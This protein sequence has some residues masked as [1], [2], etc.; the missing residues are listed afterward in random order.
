MA[1]TLRQRRY[2]MI[3][4]AMFVLAMGCVAAGTWQ[5][6]R[7]EQSVHDN[8]ALTGNA[9]AATVALSPS[10]VP[11][12][13]PAPGRDAIRFRTVTV[14]GSYLADVTVASGKIVNGDGGSYIVSPLRT[15]DG[16]IAVERG[17][18][19]A[20]RS[21]HLPPVPAAPAGTVT[22]TGR[23]DTF[24][25][26]DAA[27]ASAQARQSGVPLYPAVLKLAASQPGGDGLVTLPKPDL[28]NPAG[29]AYS[30]QHFAYVVQWYVFALI[31]L[32]A[33]FVLAR[34]EVAEAQ[35]R[36]LGVDAGELELG[37]QLESASRAK[38]D[39]S[40]A[41]VVV[42]RGAEV[43]TANGVD[44]P[45]L[46][47]AKRLADRYGRALSIG[48]DIPSPAAAPAARRDPL[49]VGGLTERVPESAEVPHRSHDSYHGSYNDY[50]WQLGLADG[51]A[52]APDLEGQRPELDGHSESP[53]AIT[54]RVIEVDDD[55]RR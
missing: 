48:A 32:A 37:T 51:A 39:S 46:A 2:A 15:A 33:P 52:Q 34:R 26:G 17:F 42:R 20:D 40:G 44:T 24:N 30:A 13:G 18:L 50:L 54:P 3:A 6:F 53:P 14:T 29:G 12:G 4:A 28:D 35:R 31:A 1:W 25:S 27:S 10:L 38:P 8:R 22:L 9:H 36:F 55:D 49:P 41:E 19:A 23:L 43:A 5:I 21:G 7:F 47:R 45:Q 11:L 16:I